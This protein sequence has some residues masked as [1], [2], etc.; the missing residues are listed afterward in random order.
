MNY[1]TVKLPAVVSEPP[2]VVIVI[3]PLVAP[4]G[5]TAMM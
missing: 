3:G 4:S 5:I 2:G 1:C